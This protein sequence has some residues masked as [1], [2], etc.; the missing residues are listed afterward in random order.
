MY[1]ENTLS[2]GP[3]QKTT[4]SLSSATGPA[5][6]PDPRRGASG[7]TTVCIARDSREHDWHNIRRLLKR[8]NLSI[9]DLMSLM[10]AKNMEARNLELM[11][12][13]KL[14]EMG[15]KPMES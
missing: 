11:T 9:V 2:H 6:C 5:E 13:E 3:C 7:P 12:A 4:D 15:P 14:A 8:L 10:V 1:A